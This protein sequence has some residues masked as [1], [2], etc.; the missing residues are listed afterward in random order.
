MLGSCPVHARAISCKEAVRALTLGLE[1]VVLLSPVLLL[2]L[3][4]VENAWNLRY[5]PLAPEKV[6]ARLRGPD[7]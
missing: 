2:S 4:L 5:A 1:V 6:L 7:W 3:V